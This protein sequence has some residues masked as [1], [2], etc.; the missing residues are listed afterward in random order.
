MKD[1]IGKSNAGPLAGIA[2]LLARHRGLIVPIFVI[3]MLLVLIVPL[4]VWLIDVLL[5]ANLALAVIVLLTVITCKSPLEFSV[6]PSLLLGATLFR[7]VL[8]VATT[9]LI[10][11]AD[12]ASAQE[13]STA[14]GQ[15]I[16]SFASFVAA[17]S[18]VVGMVLF[19]ILIIVQFVV[20]TKGAGRVSEV[21]AR[22]T[23]DAM[24]GRQM[25]ID[26]DLNAGLIDQNQARQRR[27]QVAA[28]ADF[29]GSMDGASKFVRGDAIA[30]VIITLINIGGGM[31]IGLADKG[32]TLSETA[33]VFTTLTI[34]DG[35]VSQLP[36]LMLALAAGL[37]VTRSSQ[38]QDLGQQ[39]TGQLTSR[40]GVLTATAVMLALM[41]FTGLPAVP[42]LSMAAAVGLIALIVK[43]N[44]SRNEA[45]QIES[46]KPQ[47]PEA[48][49]EKMTDLPELEIQLGLGLLP[50]LGNAND[51]TGKLVE[52]IGQIRNQIASDLGL[53]IPP[54]KIRDRLELDANTYR[55][56]LRGNPVMSGQIHPAQFLAMHD[57]NSTLD[58]IEGQPVTEP[59][60]GVRA[61]WIDRT[62]RPD[63]VSAGCTLIDAQG[64]LTISFKQLVQ[65][66]GAELMTRQETSR[67]IEQL[68]VKAPVLV[69]Q[70]IANGSRSN[71]GTGTTV[72]LGLVHKVLGN[73]L[74]ERVPILDME[75]IVQT[76]GD[77]RARTDDP[78]I[79]TEYVRQALR[80]TICGQYLAPG[81]AQSALHCVALD[82]TLQNRIEGY[83]SRPSAD[84]GLSLPTTVANRVVTALLRPLNQLMEKGL[85]PVVLTAPQ[86]RAAVH[87]LLS[88]HVPSSAVLSYAEI[89]EGVQIESEGLATYDEPA[90]HDPADMSGLS[91]AS[92][93]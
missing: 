36:A 92:C 14:A 29:Y 88:A 7:L 69:E 38:S 5:A 8:N 78:Q 13:A 52:Q 61:K 9:R 54:V 40:V 44:A 55:I 2:Q 63:A 50:L 90:S 16:E 58:S 20:I 81:T 86:V 93:N 28:E 47:T 1:T 15:V 31:A 21:A 26:A 89:C 60:F 79:L 33:S 22:F 57:D 56:L 10:L 19:A 91:G 87:R 49:I 6:F 70:V 46:T 75:V 12:A 82:P 43:R 71:A 72:S 51:Q 27:K 18:L 39:V 24:P 11:R 48:D 64:V 77:Y 76:L 37:L 59:L 35:L 17:D 73:L 67:L 41:A 80:R 66:H 45:K 4:P 30:A 62:Q 25:A 83:S 65:R 53:V 42:M 34:G 32:W 84:T 23:L 3:A 74:A 68:R 85:P